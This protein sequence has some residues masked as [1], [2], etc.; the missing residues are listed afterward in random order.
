MTTETK[1]IREKY[2]V[3][4]ER[5]AEE[6]CGTLGITDMEQVAFIHRTLKEKRT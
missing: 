4:V 3:I 5:R 6:P 2:D 1:E